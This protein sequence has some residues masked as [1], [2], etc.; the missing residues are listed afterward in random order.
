MTR[1][2]R[3]V[4]LCGLLPTLV[5]AVLSLYRPSFFANLEYGAYDTLVRAAPA[6]PPGDRI[7]IVDVDERS[8]SAIRQWPW[9]RDLIGKLIARLRDLVASTIRLDISFAESD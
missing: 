5:M 1:P 3:L 7:V 4:L 8:L 2:R 6:R 9:R